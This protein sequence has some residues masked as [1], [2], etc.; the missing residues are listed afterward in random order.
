MEVEI[1]GLRKIKMERRDEAAEE[2]ETGGWET[3]RRAEC[4]IPA[5]IRCPPPPRKK[6]P[7]MAFGKRRDPPKNGYFHPPDLEALFA[8][9]PRR[10]ACA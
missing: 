10:E 3:P 1:L 4:R 8:L 9:A 2:G 5:A 6:S 7:A